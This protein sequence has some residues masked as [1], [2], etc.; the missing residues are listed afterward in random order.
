MSAS[1]LFRAI[2]SSHSW[3]TPRIGIIGLSTP[4]HLGM[5]FS[6]AKRRAN[7]ADSEC[8]ALPIAPHIGRRTIG[9]RLHRECGALPSPMTDRVMKQPFMTRDGLT[10]NEARGRVTRSVAQSTCTDPTCSSMPA[11][12][13]GLTTCKA[14]WIGSD[15]AFCLLHDEHCGTS[16]Q[17]GSKTQDLMPSLL[18]HHDIDEAFTP[19]S[20]LSPT[21]STP[22]T[23]G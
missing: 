21:A 17:R 23:T 9:H 19:T 11:A 16:I 20:S 14:L 10:P 5:P 1:A 8:F 22:C 18:R 3:R 13:T 7:V 2:S 4:S 6:S 12:M 15:L